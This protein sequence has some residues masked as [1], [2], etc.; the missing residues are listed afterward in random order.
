MLTELVESVR[1]PDEKMKLMLRETQEKVQGT[2]SER[3]ETGTQTNNLEQKEE[4]NIQL[5]QNEEI[6]IQKNEERF[7]NLWDPLIFQ[8]LNYK[9]ARKR[10]TTARN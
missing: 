3:K 6:R 9:A 5:E 1:K 4:I 10:R 7:R 8:Y 2:N